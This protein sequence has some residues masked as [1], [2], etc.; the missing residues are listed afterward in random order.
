MSLVLPLYI[1]FSIPSVYLFVRLLTTIFSSSTFEQ[2][3]PFVYMLAPSPP[4][5]LSLL[6]FSL[7][8]IQFDRNMETWKI[9]FTHKNSLPGLSLG[10]DF[11][12][13]T[14][15]KQ[16]T[17]KKGVCVIQ[18][19]NDVFIQARKSESTVSST[20]TLIQLCICIRIACFFFYI[21]KLTH[22]WNEC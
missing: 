3:L 21:T 12:Q 11:V 9:T 6:G 7:S 18:I 2:I 16:S 19:N 1:F 17:D 22:R 5:S 8:Y 4:P 20:L 14:S 13:Y 15:S 10:I